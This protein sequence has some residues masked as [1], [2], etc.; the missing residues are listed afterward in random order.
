[1]RT[2]S[3]IPSLFGQLVAYASHIAAHANRERK[4]DQE[5]QAAQKVVFLKWLNLDLEQQKTDLQAYAVWVAS[6]MASVLEQRLRLGPRLLAPRD[7]SE[8]E[9]Q[10]LSSNLQALLEL[11]RNGHERAL[12]V[13]APIL[14][15]QEGS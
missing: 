11:E 1:V 13:S 12:P 7:A 15:P 3:K 10:L 14:T 6:D 5:L 9:W 2:L 4:P 8:A